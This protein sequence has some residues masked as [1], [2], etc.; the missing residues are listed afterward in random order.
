MQLSIP[1][2][3]EP[4]I[5]WEKI[6]LF[7]SLDPNAGLYVARIEDFVDDGMIITQPELIKGDILLRDNCEI[8]LDITKTDA[9]Y[10]FHS[11]IQKQ[12][13]NGR[14]KYFLSKPSFIKRIQ[15]RDFARVVYSTSV[16]YTLFNEQYNNKQKW[17]KSYSWDISGNGILIETKDF[18]KQNSLVLL[19]IKLFEELGINLPVLGRTHRVLLDNNIRLSGIGIITSS[20]MQGFEKKYPLNKVEKLVYNFDNIAQEKL[21]KFIFNEQI[22]QRKKGLL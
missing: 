15:R 19:K 6:E 12:N 8:I 9:I 13:N 10:R 2:I 1:K 3:P 16:E 18:V 7:T 17:Y 21:I 4:L 11:V 14:P 20:E 22:D 5:I